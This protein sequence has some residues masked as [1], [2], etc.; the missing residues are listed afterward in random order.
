MT[1]TPP[2]HPIESPEDAE[3]RLAAS[4]LVGLRRIGVLVAVVGGAIALG[5]LL[6]LGRYRDPATLVAGLR[7]LRQAPGAAPLFVLG[8]AIAATFAVPATVL[9]LAGGAIFGVGLGSLLNWTGALLGA[10]GG[11]ALA[12]VLCRGTC[13]DL[14]GERATELERMAKTHGFLG[15]LR[16]RLLPVVPFGLLNYGDALAGVR[17]RDFVLASALGLL[18]TTA[19]YTWFADRLVAGVTGAR[20]DA[21]VQAAIASVFLIALSFVPA[22][23]RRRRPAA[24]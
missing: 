8:F 14:L 21:M 17:A 15:T 19:V 9:M 11:F 1:L 6:G 16:L 18:P 24:R 7:E 2:L 10:T 3:R 20:H 22:V 5:W 13:R 23:L 4:R 12:R